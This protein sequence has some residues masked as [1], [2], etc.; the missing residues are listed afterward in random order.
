MKRLTL[1]ELKE[2]LSR[3]NYSFFDNNKP[4]NINIIGVRS[5]NREANLFDDQLHIAYRDKELR[6]HHYIF[7]C[8]TDPGTNHLF[9]P[10]SSK[11]T[12]ILVPG[13]YRGVWGLGLHQGKYRALVQIKPVK[14][15]RDANKNNILDFDESTIEEGVFGINLHRASQWSNL[16][17]VGLYSA[18][19]Q[20]VQNPKDFDFIIKACEVSALYFGNNFT[21][22][23]INE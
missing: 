21:Y 10:L 16:N 19:C 11:G 6:M 8:T 18:G 7:P 2:R 3:L 23:L 14:V 15:Y 17:E 12:A 20:V 4:Y 22:T 9:A 5:K 1:D 13:Q